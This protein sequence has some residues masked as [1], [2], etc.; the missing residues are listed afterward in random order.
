MH[1]WKSGF[2]IADPQVN[3]DG[4]H[5][6]HFDPDLPVDVLYHQLSGR[7]PFRVNRHEYYELA[8]VHAGE[9]VWQVQ[10]RFVT[11]RTGDLFVM[12]S[13]TFHRVTEH[14]KSQVKAITLFFLPEVIRRAC[15]PGDDVSYLIP[16]LH[17]DAAFPYVVPAKSGIPAEVVGLFKRIYDELPAKSDRA[18]LAVKT[19]L[20]MV[21][22]LLVN[23]YSSYR[24]AT[25]VFDRRQHALRRLRPLFACLEE[26]YG[27]PLEVSDVARTVGMSKSHF[28]RFFK[29]VTGQSFV[30]YLNQFRIA[31][32]QV[33]LAKTDLPIAEISQDVGFCDQSYF[34]LV[35]RKLMHVTP[36]QFRHSLVDSK[37]RAESNGKPE[38][39]SP[40]IAENALPGELPLTSDLLAK[41]RAPL[42]PFLK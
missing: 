41:P 22:I 8:Y 16:F 39:L 36:L 13:T 37:D 10:D 3:A 29:Q 2:V 34:G 19:Y 18:R 6:W 5:V 32:A 30:T 11:Q 20:K 14:S 15:T 38:G 35:F 7:Q 23:H 40:P 27:E 1:A 17:Q 12:G 25:E 24:V 26:R 31:K 9:L 33:L 42:G 28:M 21:L 4:V